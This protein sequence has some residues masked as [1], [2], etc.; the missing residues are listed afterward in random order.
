MAGHE[1]RP[2]LIIE[3]LAEAIAPTRYSFRSFDRQWIIPD[4]R[5]INQPNPSLWEVFCRRQV[6][7]TAPDDRSPT[8]GPALT[9]SAVVPDLHHYNGCGGRVYPLWRDREATQPNVRP[10]LLGHLSRFYGHEISAEDVLAYVAA[11]MAHPVFTARFAP[12]LKQ[13][14]L[15]VPLTA[16]R[17]LFA[18][19]AALG[20]E[21]VWL[22]CYGERFADPDAGR[23]RGAPRIAEGG[24][25]HIPDGADIPGEP[26]LPD[27]MDYDPATRRLHVGK[28]FVAGVSQAVWAYEVS[29]KQVL[30]QWFSYRRRDRTRPLIG[31]KRSPSE[32]ERIVPDEWPASYTDDLLDLLHVLG[33]LVALEPR[34]ADLLARILDGALIHEAE[35]REAGALRAKAGGEE[36]EAAARTVSA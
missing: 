16:D 13:P 33:R 12:H 21:V 9:I 32:L 28:G 34:Q 25:P 14:G 30:P 2:A 31:D 26:G 8:N 36:D 10:E 27:R 19:A 22:H 29:G 18:E 23:P 20:R 11:V 3:D 24:R 17:A 5:L 35:L 4:A 1:H 15:R 7:V 6:Y